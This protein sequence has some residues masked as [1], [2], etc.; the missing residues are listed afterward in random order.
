MNAYNTSLTRSIPAAL[1]S[2][3]YNINA[4]PVGNY[5][6]FGPS[7]SSNVV[8]TYNTSLTRGT[9]KAFTTAQDNY[10]AGKVGN[11]AL[12]AGGSSSG[13]NVEYY[14]NTLTHGVVSTPLTKTMNRPASASLGDYLLF[15]GAYYGT[16]NAVEY[17]TTTL[18]HGVCTTLSIS[19]GTSWTRPACSAGG[20]ALFQAVGK[21]NIEIYGIPY[22]LSVSVPANYTYTFN[23]ETPVTATSATTVTKT[24]GSPISGVVC[25]AATTRTGQIT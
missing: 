20:Y 8:N 6:I 12:F 7:A 17:Y 22:T 21:T 23:G 3:R 15:G 1:P 4:A 16:W 14:T 24:N 18:T 10:G 9:A 13:Q 5:A 25:K 19:N 2:N 11:Y